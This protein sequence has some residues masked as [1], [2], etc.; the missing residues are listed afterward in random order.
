MVESDLPKKQLLPVMYAII[1]VIIS[2]L[3]F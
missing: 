2:E 3:M 1:I